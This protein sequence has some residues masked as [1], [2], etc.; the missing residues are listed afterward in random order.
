MYLLERLR[1]YYAVNCPPFQNDFLGNVFVFFS[2][3]PA[4]V[5]V[6]LFGVSFWRKEVYMML[7]GFITLIDSYGVNK[8]LQAVFQSEPPFPGCGTEYGMPATASESAYVLYALLFTFPL[9]YRRHLT[10]YHALLA[11]A[12][13]GLLQAAEMELGLATPQQALAG[14]FVGIIVGI[15]WQWLIHIFIYPYFR[16]YRKVRLC[17]SGFELFRS[18]NWLCKHYPDGWLSEEENSRVDALF[19]NAAGTETADEHT[20]MRNYLSVGPIHLEGV[21]RGQRHGWTKV[22]LPP[23]SIFYRIQSKTSSPAKGRARVRQS[24][25]SGSGKRQGPH[26]HHHQ[27]HQHYHSHNHSQQNEGQ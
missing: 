11:A 9:F 4:F 16:Y 13:V 8:G 2:Y 15:S 19:D 12:G 25:S 3:A 6:F 10:L 17:V 24:G 26:Y 20:D 23:G 14:A 27:Q 21:P 7:L 5:S 1:E 18:W 22:K